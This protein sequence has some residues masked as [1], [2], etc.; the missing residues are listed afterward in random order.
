MKKTSLILFFLI[1]GINIIFA[2]TEPFILEYGAILPPS[3]LGQDENRKVT[4]VF[5]NPAGMSV[6]KKQTVKI[7]TAQDVFGYN[8]FSFAYAIPIEKFTLGI[9][10]QNFNANDI[11]ATSLSSSNGRPAITSYLLDE[12]TRFTANIAYA[13]TPELFAGLGLNLFT[14]NLA[15]TTISQGLFGTAG[16]YYQIFTDWQIGVSYQFP[17]RALQ[18]SLDLSTN[19]TNLAY[20]LN[21]EILGKFAFLQFGFLGQQINKIGFLEI[22]F[23][24]SISLIGQNT[25]DN[26]WQNNY[27]AVGP[28]MDFNF[29]ALQYLY[30]IISKEGLELP[31]NLFSLKFNF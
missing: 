28:I 13:F 11:P 21:Y 1:L 12:N 4:Q 23:S 25:W 27:L 30:V 15:Q 9:G 6:P 18:Q 5:I 14:E 26:N 2:K 22:I 29:F 8:F 17:L 16:L 31:Q 10:Y 24:P 7:D 3:F 20:S 19:Y